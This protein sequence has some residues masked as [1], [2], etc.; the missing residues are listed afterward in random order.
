MKASLAFLVVMFP[1]MFLQGLEGQRKTTKFEVGVQ[2]TYLHSN[3]SF[4][5]KWGYTSGVGGRFVYNPR[6]WLSIEGDVNFFA[7]EPNGRNVYQGGRAIQG[8]FGV[9]S[10][11]RKKRFGVFGKVRPGFVTFGDALLD[12][13]ALGP[14]VQLKTGRLTQPALDAGGVVEFYPSQRWALRFDLGNTSIFY[15][16]RSLTV[17]GSVQGQTRNSFQFSSGIL[18]RF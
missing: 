18:F 13:T 16:D 4:F 7:T 2:Y 6:N 10:G 1:L 14:P 12:I 15:R 5:G 17:G 8:L 9:K 3:G 11:I